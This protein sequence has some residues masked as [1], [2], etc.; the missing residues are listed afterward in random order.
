MEGN[1][2]ALIKAKDGNNVYQWS[3]DRDVFSILTTDTET[4][5]QMLQRLGGLIDWSKVDQHSCIKVAIDAYQEVYRPTNYRNDNGSMRTQLFMGV[6]YTNDNVWIKRMWLG[7]N[8]AYELRSG[9][10]YVNK[11]NDLIGGG[12]TII[13]AY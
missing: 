12:T 4:W 13:F 9:A 3:S 7:N 5:G 8:Y 1:I 6:A 11:T 2:M 10:D